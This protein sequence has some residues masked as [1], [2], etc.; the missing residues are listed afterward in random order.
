MGFG[1]RTR[2]GRGGR[3]TVRER[4]R[5]R[6]RKETVRRYGANNKFGDGSD[7]SDIAE[8]SANNCNNNAYIES[9]RDIVERVN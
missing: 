4:E 5:E 6:S 8:I 3:K 1:I 7:G 2:K 9:Y